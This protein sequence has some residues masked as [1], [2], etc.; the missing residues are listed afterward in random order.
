[1]LA[2]GFYVADDGPGIPVDERDRVFEGGYSTK[3]EGHGFGLASV[4]HLAVAHG[5]DISVTEGSDGGARFELTD[6]H[7]E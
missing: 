5:W 3:P 2:D 4:R 1:V 7:I 6:V